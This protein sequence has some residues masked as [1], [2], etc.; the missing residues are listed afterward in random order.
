MRTLG[1]TL[2]LLLNACTSYYYDGYDES[3][4]ASNFPGYQHQNKSYSSTNGY[5][6]K[7]Q[8]RPLTT[9]DFYML[10]N[11]P[12]EYLES[13]AWGTASSIGNAAVSNFLQR[14]FY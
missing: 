13:Q 5:H 11:H 4:Y 1:L 12:S 8:V 6:P 14:I 10:D 7:I 2:I 3:Y 9:Q